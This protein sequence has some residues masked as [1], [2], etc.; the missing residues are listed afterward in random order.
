MYLMQLIKMV[1]DEL[2]PLIEASN[3]TERDKIIKSEMARL[4]TGYA[5]LMDRQRDPINL[6]AP[7]TRFA[8]IYKYTVAH[9]DYVKQI[10]EKS[11]TL[12]EL[13]AND[14]IDI[15]CLGG[16]PGS[17][18]LGLMKYLGLSGLTPTVTCYLYDRE[19]AWGESWG[20]IAKKIGP[21]FNFYPVFQPIDVTKMESWSPL[22]EFLKADLFTMVYF[23]S[24]L[25]VWK[26]KVEP[27]FIHVFQ[28][29]KP[30]ALFLFIDN[31][32][33][34]NRF[35][36]WFRDLCDVCG[37]TIVENEEYDMCFGNEEEKD[38][39]E[40]YFSRLGWMKRESNA[41]YIIAQ[42]KAK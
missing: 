22:R 11:A 29:A 41:C 14:N 16:G 8:Y 21:K 24:E 27:F 6:E 28:K 5:E 3:D 20:T 32:D 19:L 15:A 38:D 26:S 37:L 40:P 13:L 17:D 9:A 1:L 2:Y 23:L 25:Y 18:Y 33:S 4:S 35:Q 12:Q 30:G 39:L 36:S 34:G 7:E 10:V 31:R 42:K